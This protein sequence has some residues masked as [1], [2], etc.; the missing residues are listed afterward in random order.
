MFLSEYKYTSTH[1]IMDH[2]FSLFVVP[3][4]LLLFLYSFCCSYVLFVVPISCFICF[5][6]NI[7][8]CLIEKDN[9]M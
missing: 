7:S 8:T 1:L 6:E 2:P 9:F 5:F 3:I 4:F